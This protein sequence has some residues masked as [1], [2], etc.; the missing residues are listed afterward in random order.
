MAQVAVHKQNSSNL[1]SILLLLAFLEG[2]TV[3]A[4]EMLVAKMIAPLYG[5]SLYVWSSIIGVTLIALAAGYFLGGKV[6]EKYAGLNT[7]LKLIFTVSMI[8][9]LLTVTASGII[10]SVSGY[11]IRTA[12]FFSAFILLGAPMTLLGMVPPLIIGTLTSLVKDSGRVSG[13]V[14]AISTAGGIFAT[15][16]IGFYVLPAYGIKGP[17]LMIAAILMAFTIAGFI[18]GKKPLFPVVG[19]LVMLALVKVHYTKP[20][21]MKAIKIIKQL[22]SVYGQINIIDNMYKQERILVINNITQTLVNFDALNVSQMGYV[23][24]LSIFSSLALNDNPDAKA[25]LCGL[26]GGSIMTELTTMGFEAD[27][28]EIDPRMPELGTKYFEFDKKSC[29]IYIDDARHFLRN[30]SKEYDLIVLDLLT[31]EVQPSHIFTI[32]NFKHLHSLLSDEGILII[33]FQGYIYG[34][35]GRASR[36]ILKTLLAA[37]YKVNVF[38][39]PEEIRKIVTDI[40]FIASANE[41]NFEA[42]DY[43]KRNS[44]CRRAL[45]DLTH[46]HAPTVFDL[47]DA[48]LLTDDNGPILDL[49][50]RKGNDDWRSDF[51]NEYR[52][53]TEQ[54]LNVPLF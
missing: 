36:S 22:E 8:L 52:I 46:L 51:V 21:R 20:P 32:E 6:S 45:L 41:L 9:G 43:A 13:M 4:V 31:S 5:A 27:A 50:A 3:M 10:S 38:F 24:N 44:C 25:L 19:I 18:K 14:Y 40:F 29:E 12:S 39:N 30:S 23:H 49:Y 34:E 26:G 33:N 37:E 42:L 2:A 11:S 54:K 35:E 15:L 47:E 7:L 48:I 28:V 53:W 16:T 17:L 1:H